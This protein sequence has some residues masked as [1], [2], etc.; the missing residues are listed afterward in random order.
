MSKLPDNVCRNLISAYNDILKIALR[1]YGAVRVA[2]ATNRLWK[3][4]SF[5][6][7]NRLQQKLT[8]DL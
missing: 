3:A 2:P 1:R 8:G 4:G 6:Q 5:E 7:L